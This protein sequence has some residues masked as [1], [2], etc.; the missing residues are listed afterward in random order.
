MENLLWVR[1]TFFST[2]FANLTMSGFAFYLVN[3]YVLARLK[4]EFVLLLLL[5]LANKEKFEF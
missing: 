3:F 4:R 5:L 1:M 2:G